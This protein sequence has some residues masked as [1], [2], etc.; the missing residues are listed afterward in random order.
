[1]SVEFTDNSA[2]VKSALKNKVSSALHE[3]GGELVSGTRR[4]SRTD[5]GQTKGSYEYKV[6]NGS[7]EATVYV[8]SNYK[9]AIWE[10]FG[11]GEYALNNDGRKGGWV[12]HSAK[13][14]KYYHTT[15]KKPKRPLYNAFNSLRPSMLKLIR[16][17]LKQL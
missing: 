4:N 3:C 16:Q 17:R 7:N 6:V 1:M 13:N 15:G 2:R 12:Y 9:N 8:G 10:E 5:T 14:D 11:T